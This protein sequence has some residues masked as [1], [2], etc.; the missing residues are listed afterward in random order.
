MVKSIKLL[1]FS[2]LSKY[3]NTYFS[4]IFLIFN[5]LYYFITNYCNELVRDIQDLKEDIQNAATDEIKLKKSEKLSE[6]QEQLELLKENVSRLY[7]T[8]N[9]NSLNTER[10]KQAKIYFDAGQ[11]READNLLNAKEIASDLEKLLVAEIRNE[12]E[13][14][15]KKVEIRTAK[16]NIAN[17]YLAKAQLKTILYSDPNWYDEAE[18]YFKEAL[19][20]APTVE[21]LFKYALFL[22]KH[23]QF[24]KALDV[25]KKLHS[26]YFSELTLQQKAEFYQ[27]AA[28]LEL[29]AGDQ[30][31]EVVYCFN[32]AFSY[33]SDLTKEKITEEQQLKLANLYIDVGNFW[34]RTFINSKNN[35]T[36]FAEAYALLWETRKVMNNMYDTFGGKIAT[37]NSWLLELV[38]NEVKYNHKLLDDFNYEKNVHRLMNSYEILAE[39]AYNHA[40]LINESVTLSDNPINR[41][42]AY[43]NRADILSDK[44]GIFLAFSNHHGEEYLT[45]SLLYFCAAMEDLKIISGFDIEKDDSDIECKAGRI[46]LNISSVFRKMQYF[47]KNTYKIA[48]YISDTIVLTTKTNNGKTDCIIDCENEEIAHI[49][50]G[51]EVFETLCQS[52]P[53]KYRNF[54]YTTYLMRSEFYEKRDHFDKAIQDCEK[55]IELYKRL[56]NDIETYSGV[57]KS[58]IESEL[59]LAHVYMRDRVNMPDKAIPHF[60]NA[61]KTCEDLS[62]KLPDIYEWKLIEIYIETAKAYAWHSDFDKAKS[63]IFDKSYKILLKLLSTDHRSNDGMWDK[64]ISVVELFFMNMQH[65]FKE[66]GLEIEIWRDWIT[67]TWE[68]LLDAVYKW[69]EELKKD[70]NIVLPVVCRYVNADGREDFVVKH[71]QEEYDTILFRIVRLL[72][73]MYAGYHKKDEAMALITDALAVYNTL[74]HRVVADA[75]ILRHSIY[76]HQVRKTEYKKIT[77]ILETMD[78][79][80]FNGAVAEFRQMESK[81]VFEHA[82]P[83]ESD[84]MT[85]NDIVET[86]RKMLSIADK[87]E[88]FAKIHKYDVADCYGHLGYA[89]YMSGNSHEAE[90]HITLKVKILKEVEAFDLPNEYAI[91]MSIVHSQISLGNFYA[92]INDFVK[93]IKVWAEALD[94]QIKFVLKH[95]PNVTDTTKTRAGFVGSMTPL[96][97]AETVNVILRN[98]SYTLEDYFNAEGG[99]NAKEV[100]N[101]NWETIKTIGSIIPKPA[102]S[103]IPFLFYEFIFGAKDDFDLIK[104][105]HKELINLIEKYDAEVVRRKNN[106]NPETIDALFPLDT[107]KRTMAFYTYIKNVL[108]DVRSKYFPDIDK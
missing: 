67:T 37:S 20:A 101:E 95:G 25:I 92:V 99:D 89:L 38:Y 22:Q 48:D 30:L 73:E 9:K 45:Y 59:H 8:F 104:G 65:Q 81:I 54:L 4:T 2:Q 90:K 23:N 55:N 26:E 3:F 51:L 105:K 100:F 64:W 74:S 84:G 69:L 13:Y 19:K 28:N 52:N 29:Q 14:E 50:K 72:T 53:L 75:G 46:H 27:I 56:P 93:A 21:A 31:K 96:I 76:F 71:F 10:L 70:V 6:K 82:N 61:L 1:I 49:N 33:W 98:M 87:N 15:Q 63:F 16:I 17:E 107:S 7:E 88:S 39:E 36:V 41:H 106:D 86:Y 80:A 68:Y 32:N 5:P 94:L 85:W 60:E 108:I 47:G 62:A 83:V 91:V 18:K 40:Y 35:E 42:R 102:F 11:F 34:N 78:D 58:Y 66:G 57:Y 43:R 103:L 12:Q 24:S 79:G 97:N 77:E 44:G